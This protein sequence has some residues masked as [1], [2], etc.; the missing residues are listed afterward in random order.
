MM[1]TMDG[2]L[3]HPDKGTRSSPCALLAVCSV[4]HGVLEV[5]SL[6]SDKPFAFYLLLLLLPT[7]ERHQEHAEVGL[8]V[9]AGR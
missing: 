4:G 6:R 8:V 1:P 3:H 7:G 9:Q 5:C 2:L